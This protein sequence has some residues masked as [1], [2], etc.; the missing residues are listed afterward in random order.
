MGRCSY[1]ISGSMLTL[2]EHICYAYMY[3]Y[4]FHAHLHMYVTHIHA[5]ICHTHRWCVRMVPTY[6]YMLTAGACMCYTKGACICL[7]TYIHMYTFTNM[8]ALMLSIE[9]LACQCLGFK[10]RARRE[11]CSLSLFL[12]LSLY[13]CVYVCAHICT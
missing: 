11:C 8:Y 4:V 13:I 3:I 2:G 9:C 12:S 5:Y 6:I 10:L 7:G 1:R